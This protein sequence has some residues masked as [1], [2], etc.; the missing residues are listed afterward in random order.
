MKKN[1]SPTSDVQNIVQHFP[2]GANHLRSN[3]LLSAASCSGCSNL[4]VSVLTSTRPTPPVSSKDSWSGSHDQCHHPPSQGEISCELLWLIPHM[5]VPTVRYHWQANTCTGVI[6]VG[7]QKIKRN[8][9]VF[10][11]SIYRHENLHEPHPAPA[12]QRWDLVS[13]LYMLVLL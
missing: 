13:I 1:R 7:I 11:F 8:K 6:F 3:S 5:V 2:P 12:S 4:F 10:E 9:T